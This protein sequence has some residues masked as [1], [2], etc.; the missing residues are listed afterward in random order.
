[1]RETAEDNRVWRL[2]NQ[3]LAAKN[4]V[5][6]DNGHQPAHG[7]QD[8]S[9]PRAIWTQNGVGF[10]LLDAEADIS[11]HAIDPVSERDVADIEQKA[12]SPPPR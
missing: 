6:I 8:R 12:H 1:M 9:L 7:A 3:R 4:Y 5:S 2:G 11:H 10:P